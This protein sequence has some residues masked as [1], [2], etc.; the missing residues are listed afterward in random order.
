MAGFQ[1]TMLAEFYIEALCV[2]SVLADEVWELWDA[3]EITDSEAARCPTKGSSLNLPLRILMT[4]ASS[5]AEWVWRRHLALWRH[6]TTST[7]SITD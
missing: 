5:R 6:A 2:D 1:W 4:I 3:G 7:K